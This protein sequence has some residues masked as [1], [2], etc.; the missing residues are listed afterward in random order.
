MSRISPSKL[1]AQR[2]L[3]ADASIS[4]AEIRTWSPERKTLPSTTASTFSSRAISAKGLRV[5][6]Y[7]MADVRE[8]TRSVLICPRSVINSSVMPSAK[9]SCD[10]SPERFSSGST[11]KERIAG[12]ERPHGPK[13]HDRAIARDRNRA[14]PKP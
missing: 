7:V 13:V 5:F 4:W 8:I 11:A 2:C 9:Y 6:L 10:A 12:D 3:S 14:K 1:S